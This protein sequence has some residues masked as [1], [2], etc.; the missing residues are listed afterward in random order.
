MVTSQKNPPKAPAALFLTDEPAAC[1]LIASDANALLIGFILDQQVTVQKAF[2]GPL[3]LKKRLGSIKP[4]AIAAMD[5]DTLNTAFTEKP[6]IHRYPS[7]MAQRV[8]DA[9]QLVV[10]E[11]G[12]NAKKIWDDASSY[13]DLEKRLGAIP[14]I[15]PGKVTALTAILVNRYGYE[16]Q[17]WKAPKSP[18]GSLGD[19]QSAEDLAEY[20][21]KKRA[22][23]A[24]R[25]AQKK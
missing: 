6:S 15:G 14:G 7:T 10:D 24:A 18:W 5:I 13:A 4:Q 1:K 19:V 2:A 20:Q 23:K 8:R 21:R 17:G 16:F 9:M 12:G 22:F 3:D 25:K 11:Y